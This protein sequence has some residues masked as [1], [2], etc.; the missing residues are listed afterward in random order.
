MAE[1]QAEAQAEEGAIF[2]E[3]TIHG[4]Q[5]PAPSD[6]AVVPQAE[7]FPVWPQLHPPPVGINPSPG[8]AAGQG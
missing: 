8:A 1:A 3:H 4:S 6:A 5:L 2:H 7:S